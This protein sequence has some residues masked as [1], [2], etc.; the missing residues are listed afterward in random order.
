MAVKR[1]RD[2]YGTRCQRF[3][4]TVLLLLATLAWTGD[5]AEAQEVIRRQNF[6]ER[7]FGGPRQRQAQPP[8][9]FV[10]PP[11]QTR[12]RAA[13]A[14][15]RRARTRVPSDHRPS[16]NAAAPA[17]EKLE[18]ALAVLVVGDFLASGLA[19]GLTA[20]YAEAP[21]VRIVE[22]SNGSSGFVRNDYYD[23]I[24]QIGPIL[25]EV[26]P[27]VIVVMIG[28][29]D[30]QSLVL[31]GQ[32]ERPGT[33]AWRREYVQRIENFTKTIQAEGVPIIWTG[34]PPFRSQAMSTDMLAFNDLYKQATEEVGG[35]F[36]DIWDGFADENGAFITTG[37]DLNGQSVRLRSDD[38]INLTRPA[39][40][41]VAFYVEQPLNKLLGSAASPDIASEELE[42]LP[43]PGL[44]IGEPEDLSRTPP[45][46]LASP[47]LDGAGMLMGDEPQPILPASQ[48][49]QSAHPK[50]ADYFLLGNP[51]AK[52]GEVVRPLDRD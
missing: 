50:R 34:L 8:A 39:K 3:L 4:L 43:P 51:P 1:P 42:N 25:E 44:A 40:R 12:T 16:R 15:Q 2:R 30:R 11:A 22:R 36:V 33:E 41:K 29:N 10:E 47:Q 49:A 37:P 26:D 31:N 35:T 18:N 13:P 45:I 32:V 5:A 46:S 9:A 20:A 14:P 23:W 48:A 38:G 21:G 17:A 52:D 24:A 7:L 19:E 6:F 27:A 28:S